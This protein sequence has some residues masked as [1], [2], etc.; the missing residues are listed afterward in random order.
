MESNKKRLD[1]NQGSKKK[2]KQTLITQYFNKKPEE[3]TIKYVY[4]YKGPNGET[5]FVRKMNGWLEKLY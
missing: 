2:Q 1:K 4:H 3:N 5:L